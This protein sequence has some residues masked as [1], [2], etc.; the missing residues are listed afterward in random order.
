MGA[1]HGEEL[2]F[3]FGAP[4]VDGM[5]HFSKNYTRAEVALSESIVQY[6]AN[7]IRTG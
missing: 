4:L 1:V 5:G 2:S 6:F 3:V 7:F